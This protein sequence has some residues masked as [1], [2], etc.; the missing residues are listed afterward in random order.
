MNIDGLSNIDRDDVFVEALSEGS[1]V[2][3]RFS[4]SADARV[5][6]ELQSFLLGVHDLLVTERPSGHTIKVVVDFRQ[7]E[8]MNSAC[9]KAFIVWLSKVR[10]LD[11]TQQYLIHFLSSEQIHWQRRSLRALSCF[12][13]NIVRIGA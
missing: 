5:K 7:L 13:A 6:Q 10:T 3:I 11:A 1:N 12:A 4:G 9:F 8:F 2:R